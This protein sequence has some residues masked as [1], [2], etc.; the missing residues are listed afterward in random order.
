MIH[1]WDDAL[2]YIRRR[3]RA[4]SVACWTF[5]VA[6]A[7]LYLTNFAMR[8]F[9]Y[10]DSLLELFQN[11]ICPVVFVGAI[12]AV[13]WKYCYTT[14]FI[15]D[16]LPAVP[17]IALVAPILA[18]F[19]ACIFH[20]PQRDTIDFSITLLASLAMATAPYALRNIQK[21]CCVICAETIG[22]ILLA[23]RLGYNA[24]AI[25]TILMVAAMLILS[26]PK[27][28]WINGDE[29]YIKHKT[30]LAVI[31]LI[32]AF[33]AMVLIEDTQVLESFVICSYGRPSL[34]SSAIVNKAC[35][36][37]LTNANWIGAADCVY[38][39]DSIFSNRVFTYVLGTLGWVGV[40]PLLL[41]V[42]LMI[43]SGIY[44]SRRS[45]RVQHYF[46]VV[47]LSIISMQTIGYLLMCAGWDELLFPELCPFLDGGMFLN[48]MFLCMATKVLPPKQIKLPDDFLAD[49]EQKLDDILNDDVEEDEENG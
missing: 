44:I 18:A 7:V 46:A 45:I 14:K 19:F 43:T 6:I 41:A 48:T 35:A 2:K 49:L 11:F 39:M 10:Q 34:G 24:A 3:R 36:D 5:V 22:F 25:V 16:Q 23:A 12:Y 38:P 29:K 17:M 28:E 33:L 26:L 13:D 8:A 4:H 30:Q 37:M 47:Y 31:T 21:T 9:V 20:D 15:C 32:S 42:V 1:Y 40:I 27:L